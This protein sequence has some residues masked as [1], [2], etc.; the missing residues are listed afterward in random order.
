MRAVGARKV[1]KKGLTAGAI[2][3][4]VAG[5]ITGVVAGIGFPPSILAISVSTAIGALTG[6]V[7]GGVVG[8]LGG[9]IY[10]G[11]KT[12][13]SLTLQSLKSACA[14][15]LPVGGKNWIF[16][17]KGRPTAWNRYDQMN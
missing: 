8:G 9:A 3:G 7:I 12:A 11:A 15:R 4:A 13:L 10:H 1:S 2:T 6:A 5:L 17:K 14:V 16:W